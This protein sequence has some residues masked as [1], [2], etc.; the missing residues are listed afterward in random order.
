MDYSKLLQSDPLL[1]LLCLL[2]LVILWYFG[3]RI[4]DEWDKQVEDFQDQLSTPIYYN[5][6]ATW[7]FTPPDAYY[8]VLNVPVTVQPDEIQL[9]VEQQLLIN[10]LSP[11]E[12]F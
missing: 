2:I 12:L 10:K 9:L 3:C 7:S 4:C 5:L 6:D 1:G 8:G 11:K